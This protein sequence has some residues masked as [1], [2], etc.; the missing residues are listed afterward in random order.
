M[1]N[2]IYLFPTCFRALHHVIY[3]QMH[4]NTNPV[5]VKVKQSENYFTLSESL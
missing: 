3:E 1:V 5:R 4:A 2:R